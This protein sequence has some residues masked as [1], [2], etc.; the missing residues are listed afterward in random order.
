MIPL[1]PHTLGGDLK[2]PWQYQIYVVLLGR[3]RLQC[4][5]GG[6]CRTAKTGRLLRLLVCYRIDSDFNTVQRVACTSIIYVQSTAFSR[7]CVADR[8]SSSPRY[9][10]PRGRIR[11]PTRVLTTRFVWWTSRRLVAFCGVPPKIVVL[12][13]LRR[14]LFRVQV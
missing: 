9:S 8:G 4:H 5:H 7:D 1:R 13:S 3:G 6:F 2:C 11:R 12:V 14:R 10:W